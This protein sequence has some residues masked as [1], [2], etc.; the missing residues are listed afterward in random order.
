MCNILLTENP[1]EIGP[2][3]YKYT[4]KICESKILY[5]PSFGFSFSSGIKWCMYTP[6]LDFG[7]MNVKT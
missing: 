4:E 6:A 2:K 7:K 1:V 3:N 5:F